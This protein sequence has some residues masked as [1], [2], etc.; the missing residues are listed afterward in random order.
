MFGLWLLA[1]N[2]LPISIKKIIFGH[3]NIYVSM[4]KSTGDDLA[5]NCFYTHCKEPK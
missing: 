3:K 2:K 1:P 4:G 5:K